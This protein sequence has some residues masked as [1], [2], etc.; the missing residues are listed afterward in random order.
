MSIVG[1]GIV[2]IGSGDGEF[3]GEFVGDVGYT[4]TESGFYFLYGASNGMFYTSSDATAK[5]NMDFTVNVNGVAATSDEL[6]DFSFSGAITP[7]GYSFRGA[8]HA[9][10]YA[11]SL[12]AG[13]IL[14]VTGSYARLCYFYLVKMK[15]ASANYQ[16]YADK[17]TPFAITK[18]GRYFLFPSGWGIAYN[19][20]GGSSAAQ[21]NANY[22]LNVN[23]T[24]VTQ[25][26]EDIYVNSSSRGGYTTYVA[27]RQRWYML[28]LS[29]GDEITITGNVHA[30]R[31][32]TYI[33]Q[34]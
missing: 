9:I 8:G 19:G 13:D 10:L 4:V 29:A 25:N 14:T 26:D 5:N 22:S 28:D 1:K 2:L 34:T 21:N 7:S 17:S 27:I 23:G 31:N 32:I 30:E 18:K 11:L 16:G 33:V 3:T 15:R 6:N 24:A 20:S 12:S